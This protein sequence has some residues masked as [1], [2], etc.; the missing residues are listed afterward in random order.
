MEKG[1]ERDANQE[2]ERFIEWRPTTVSITIPNQEDPSQPREF[3]LTP[4][5][6]CQDAVD[7]ELLSSSR[8]PCQRLRAICLTMQV[9]LSLTFQ[10]RITIGLVETIFAKGAFAPL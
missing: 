9:S 4:L 7:A 8:L 2:G 5:A 1:I 6:Q 3:P 10:V